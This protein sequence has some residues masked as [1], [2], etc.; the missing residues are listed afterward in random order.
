MDLLFSFGPHD[1]FRRCTTWRNRIEDCVPFQVPMKLWPISNWSLFK[2]TDH[3]CFSNHSLTVNHGVLDGPI[4]C[5]ACECNGLNIALRTFIT[6]IFSMASGLTSCIPWS[7]KERILA[8]GNIEG[9][10]FGK[11]LP[12][13]WGIDMSDVAPRADANQSKRVVESSRLTTLPD[14]LP[15]KNSSRSGG[16]GGDGT[17]RVGPQPNIAKWMRP[18]HASRIAVNWCILG[19]TS[20]A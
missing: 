16:R 6:Q 2:R 17:S 12:A 19:I 3:H 8:N 9:P 7:T 15:K 1:I 13:P 11:S 4:V 5:H 10:Y 18:G 20:L 14:H